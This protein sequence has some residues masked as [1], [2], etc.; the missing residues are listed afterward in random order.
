VIKS[1]HFE[2]HNLLEI[3]FVCGVCR[4]ASDALFLIV[5]DVVLVEVVGHVVHAVDPLTASLVGLKRN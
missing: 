1:K 5:V 2:S 3:T 4:R